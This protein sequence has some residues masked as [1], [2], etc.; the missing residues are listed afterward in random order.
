M[1]KTP[2]P[3]DERMV[4]AYPPAAVKQ[5]LDKYLE[6]TGQSRSDFL[7]EAIKEKLE[8]AGVYQSSVINVGGI[9]KKGGTT[10][11]V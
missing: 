7:T 2:R 11:T 1:S 5:K 3:I 6:K 10:T 9:L 4:K 8:R